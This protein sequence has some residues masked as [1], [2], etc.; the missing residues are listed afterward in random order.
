MAIPPINSTI[1]KV[2]IN[3]ITQRPSRHNDRAHSQ[4]TNSNYTTTT[5]TTTNRQLHNLGRRIKSIAGHRYLISRLEQHTLRQQSKIRTNSTMCQQR[6]QGQHQ[7]QAKY[8]THHQEQTTTTNITVLTITTVLITTLTITLNDTT[9]RTRTTN[10]T[11]RVTSAR[12]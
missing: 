10:I 6:L 3:T 4:F 2:Y 9:R 7:L 11:R 12:T 8:H 5:T 1:I